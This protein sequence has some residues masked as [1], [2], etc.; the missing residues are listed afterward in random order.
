MFLHKH[1]ASCYL[2]RPSVKQGGCTIV[3]RPTTFCPRPNLRA[4]ARHVRTRLS[5]CATAESQCTHAKP[6]TYVHAEIVSLGAS[7][8][9]P[10]TRKPR[11]YL[12][13]GSAV[14]IG[15]RAESGVGRYGRASSSL[16]ARSREKALCDVM[17][18]ANSVFSALRYASGIPTGYVKLCHYGNT[19]TIHGTVTLCRDIIF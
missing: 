16:D 12:F 3:T 7:A 1:V 17:P 18:W 13:R 14:K 10:H 8:R 9:L 19:A 11:T 6:L 5:V 2:A 15:E 4:S